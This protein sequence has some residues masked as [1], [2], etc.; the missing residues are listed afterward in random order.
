MGGIRLGQGLTVQSREII[1][2]LAPH[3]REG[4]VVV[5]WPQTFLLKLLT[6][7]PEIYIM[8]RGEGG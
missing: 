7:G 1:F 4:S 6:G 3:L 8:C 5:V 2:I